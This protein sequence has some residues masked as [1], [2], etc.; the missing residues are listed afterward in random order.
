MQDDQTRQWASET[1]TSMKTKT[2]F[3]VRHAK[4]SR[5]DPTL[6]DRD[7]PL[8]DRGERDAPKMGRRLAKR[9]VDP[10]LLLSSPA[11]RALATTRILARKLHCK[12]KNIV[13]D[14][15]L[16]P[17][18]PAEMLRVI[19]GLDDKLDCVMLIG[20]NPGLLA[21]A[22]RLSSSVSRMP[23]SAVAEFVFGVKSWSRI[24]K[25]ALLSVELD[26][27]RKS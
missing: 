16:Y 22:Q 25:A 11:T 15:R 26:Y 12:R 23:T 4:S 21:L 14:P 13:K 24:G 10:D 20:H 7:R 18:R 9:H 8:T 27:P 3:L 19:Q 17:G 6:P 2:L 1:Q 5:D